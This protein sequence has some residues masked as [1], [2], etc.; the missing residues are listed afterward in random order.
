MDGIAPWTD[1]E[2]LASGGADRGPVAME[3]AAE[4]SVAPM[5]ALRDG[6][7]NDVRSA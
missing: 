7:W 2:S 4:G 6:R 1:G 3:Y 5:V